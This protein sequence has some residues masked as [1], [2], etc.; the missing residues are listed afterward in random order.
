M[1]FEL[2]YLISFIAV[3]MM[4]RGYLIYRMEKYLGNYVVLPMMVA[5]AALHF[6]KPLGETLGS[7]G[8]AYILGVLALKSKNIYG[9]IFIH[10]GVAFLMEVFALMFQP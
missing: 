4:F 5:Y 1:Q 3:E 8:G 6:G 7:V 10:M 2:F 9:G